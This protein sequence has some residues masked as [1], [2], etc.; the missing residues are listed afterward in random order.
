MSFETRLVEYEAAGVCEHSSA[1]CIQ[2]TVHRTPGAYSDL[3]AE[4]ASVISFAFSSAMR[5]R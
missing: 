3:K 2:L 4:Y 5:L 1:V